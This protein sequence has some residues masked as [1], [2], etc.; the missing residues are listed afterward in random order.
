MT[1]IPDL[2]PYDYLPDTVPAGVEVLAVGW[3]DPGHDFPT[4]DD[5]AGDDAD[6]DADTDVD[7]VFGRN[8]I[9]LAADHFTAAT[10]GVHGCRFR[11]LI[12]ADFQYHAVYGTRVLFLGHAEIRVVTPDGRWLSAPT[13]VV[14]Y[15]RDHGYRPPAEFVEAVTAMRVAPGDGG[16]RDGGA[17]ARI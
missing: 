10:R 1:Y 11:H 16:H 9:T 15:I 2:S 6:A 17:G 5:D 14:H 12:E 4:A 3:L 8:L 13:L 7:P